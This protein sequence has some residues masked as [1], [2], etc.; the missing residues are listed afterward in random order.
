VLEVHTEATLGDAKLFST[1]EASI[2]REVPISTRDAPRLEHASEQGEV[3]EMNIDS[4][5]ESFSP[6][7]G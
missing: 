4:S 6:V 1:P 3:E 5:R 2:D 7:P